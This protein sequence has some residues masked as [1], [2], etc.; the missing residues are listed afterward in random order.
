M[1]PSLRAIVG[2]LSIAIV[3][4]SANVASAGPFRDFFRALH[5]AIAHPHETP[6]P[7]RSSRSS[8]KRNETPPSDTSNSQTSVR[9]VPAPPSQ[10]DIRWAK[11]ASGAS[12]QKTELTYGTPTEKSSPVISR[13]VNGAWVTSQPLILRGERSDCGRASRRREAVSCRPKLLLTCAIRESQHYVIGCETSLTR[14]CSLTAFGL[15]VRQP[16]KCQR[17]RN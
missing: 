5:S 17:I 15:P 2:S 9:P 16:T 10:R 13:N 14:L 7:H 11:A 6:R 8:H 4:S 1:K 12:Q 3:I